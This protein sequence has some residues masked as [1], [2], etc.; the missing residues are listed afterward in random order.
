[1]SGDDLFA[2]SSDASICGC[3][4]HRY[5][6]SRRWGSKGGPTATFIMLNPSTADADVDDPTIRRCI[7]FARREGCTGLVVVNLYA[8]RATKPA[9][10][11]TADDPVGPE[12]DEAISGALRLARLHG[13]PVI[14]AWGAHARSDRVG[15]VR[16]LTRGVVALTCLG[17]T[18]GGHPRHPLYVR[19]DQPLVELPH[20]SP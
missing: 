18:E 16:E 6:L 15:A 13:G 3:G 4:R 1:M 12:N 17:V 10:L 9:D 5:R 11:W 14:A 2:S 8:W 19:G 7:G 20:P